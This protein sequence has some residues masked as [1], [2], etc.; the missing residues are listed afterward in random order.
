M[1]FCIKYQ[2]LFNTS[3]SLL[4]V[5]VFNTDKNRPTTKKVC[6]SSHLI[7]I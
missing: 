5:C 6:D 4:Y 3:V 1:C 2:F 7:E